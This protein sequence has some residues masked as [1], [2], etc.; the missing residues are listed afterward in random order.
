MCV[1]MCGSK[2]AR[3]SNCTPDILKYVPENKMCDFPVLVLDGE[4]LSVL[5][6]IIYDCVF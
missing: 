5:D 1:E 6:I 2:I 3:L 4:I